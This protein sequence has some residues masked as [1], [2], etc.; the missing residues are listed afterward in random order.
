MKNLKLKKVAL[1]VLCIGIVFSF[2]SCSGTVNDTLNGDSDINGSVDMFFQSIKEQDEEKLKEVYMGSNINHVLL[3]SDIFGVVDKKSR[4]EVKKKMLDF[5][6][7]IKGIEGKGNNA[8]AKIEIKTY[9]FGESYSDATIEMIKKDYLKEDAVH[10]KKWEEGIIKITKKHILNVKKSYKGD[11]E[12][13]L[14]KK[15]G[16]WYVREVDDFGDFFNELLGDFFDIMF[17]GE[18][19]EELDKAIEGNEGLY[20]FDWGW[21]DEDGE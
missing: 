4:Q 8:V 9:N 7:N 13:S 16:K 3:N 17:K 11:F 10:D 15:N 21:E 6:Y 18:G 20:S 1:I 5:D 12:L 19:S 14:K 2:C